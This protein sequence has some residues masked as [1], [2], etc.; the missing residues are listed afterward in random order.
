M[1]SGVDYSGGMRQCSA[2]RHAQSR[3]SSQGQAPHTWQGSW[4]HPVHTVV[5]GSGGMGLIVAY[6]ALFA[7]LLP[8]PVV[9]RLDEDV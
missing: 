7:A 1:R 3:P 6:G 2:R 8:H 5:S 9:Y 4:L